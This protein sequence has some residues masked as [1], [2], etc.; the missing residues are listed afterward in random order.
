MTQENPLKII[1]QAAKDRSKK[2][3]LS[4]KNLG[5]LPSTIGKLQHLT[6]LDLSD[7]SLSYY[8]WNGKQ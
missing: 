6:W 1:E 3:D 5:S 2:L 4:R 7:N 8:L